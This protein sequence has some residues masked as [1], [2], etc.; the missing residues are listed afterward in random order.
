MR[1]IAGFM[2]G[3]LIPVTWWVVYSWRSPYLN[4]RKQHD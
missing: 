2:V 3:V 1:V 4:K